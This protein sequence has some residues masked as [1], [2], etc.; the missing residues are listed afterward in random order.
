MEVNP[1]FSPALVSCAVHT[2]KPYH[3]RSPHYFEVGSKLIDINIGDLQGPWNWV[4]GAGYWS[5]EKDSTVRP[6]K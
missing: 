6:R 4:D 1:F 3:E 2:V 5:A